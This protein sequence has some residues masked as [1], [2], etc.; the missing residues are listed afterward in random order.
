MRCGV[1]FHLLP[2]LTDDDLRTELN[3]LN[4][5]HRKKLLLAIE[6]EFGKICFLVF[7]MS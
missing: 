1:T 4:G 5:V 3:V 7:K 2:H 6:E